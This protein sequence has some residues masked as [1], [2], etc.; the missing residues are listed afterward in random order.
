MVCCSTPYHNISAEW[1]RTAPSQTQCKLTH[2]S[3][4]PNTGLASRKLPRRQPLALR[5]RRHQNS[6][7]ILSACAFMTQLTEDSAHSE[8]EQTPEKAGKLLKCIRGHSLPYLP[9]DLEQHHKKMPYH[10]VTRVLSLVSAVVA[11]GIAIAVPCCCRCC[12]CR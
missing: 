12:C 2:S 6:E 1:T 8:S 11:T 4:N 5:L 3:G 7:E 10:F 9:T